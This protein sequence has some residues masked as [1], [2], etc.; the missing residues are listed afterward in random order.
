MERTDD[1][2]LLGRRKAIQALYDQQRTA[3]ADVAAALANITL[4]KQAAAAAAAT[5]PAAPAASAAA[6]VS[7]VSCVAACRL[8]TLRHRR[9]QSEWRAQVRGHRRCGLAALERRALRSVPGAGD[10][11]AFALLSFNRTFESRSSCCLC[12]FVCVCARN[13][14]TTLSGDSRRE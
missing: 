9:V 12:D 3:I 6:G 10:Q 13:E 4:L 7:T 8:T 1:A 2:A 5:A 11:A 14:L